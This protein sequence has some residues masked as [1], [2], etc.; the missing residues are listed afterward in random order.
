MTAVW[1]FN[2]AEDQDTRNLV[3][4]SLKAGKSRFGWSQKDEH[5]LRI[6]NNWTEWHSWQRFLLEIKPGDWIVHIN[7]PDYGH[8]VAVQV[9]SAYEF[10][11]GLQCEWGTDFRH[12]FRINKETLI[13]FDRNDPNVLPTVNLRPRQR[14][15]RVH[16]VKDF[17]AS[18]D[19][20]RKNRVSL[21][22]NETR[23]EFHLRES[24]AP[25]L[26]GIAELIHSMNKSKHLEGFL[27]KVFRKIP[28][29]VHVRENGSGWGTD[30]GADLI[31][32]TKHS[33]GNLDFENKIVVQIKSYEG[34]HY[35][36][37]AVEQIKTAIEKF[38]ASAAMLLSTASQTDALENRILEVANE[39]DVRIDLIA[40]DDLA[41]F[42]IRNAPE[43]VFNLQNS[44]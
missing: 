18:L 23:E 40:G 20:L 44:I 33:I 26:A 8:C 30:Y 24:T 31:V 5:D 38:G 34:K 4:E 32:E 1:A 6:P 7:T 12:C 37:D 19:N 43:L 25:Y 22:D 14:Y 29:V 2:K 21:K 36:L 17:L 42:V 39:L 3:Y 27:A 35:D 9:E 10:D 28:C 16:N 11:E 13:D 15:H 41:R